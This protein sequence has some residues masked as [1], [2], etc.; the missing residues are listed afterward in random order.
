MSGSRRDNTDSGNQSVRLTKIIHRTVCSIGVVML[1]V[2]TILAFLIIFGYWANYFA[3]WWT[4]KISSDGVIGLGV[5]GFAITI[6]VGYWLQ[7]RGMR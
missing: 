1:L 7:I 3:L 4:D 2:D 5:I 6:F